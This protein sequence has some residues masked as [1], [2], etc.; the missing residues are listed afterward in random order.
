MQRKRRR[1]RASQSTPLVPQSLSLSLSSVPS[2]RWPGTHSLV[3]KAFRSSETIR[4]IG[5]E[6]DEKSDV[7]GQ[8]GE[9]AVGGR[10][11][12]VSRCESWSEGRC[13][14]DD[15]L[16]D[17]YSQADEPEHEGAK[18]GEREKGIEQGLERVES[19]RAHTAERANQV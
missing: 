13:D 12:S 10:E 7:G 4:C 8:E 18:E 17:S 11:R 2:K 6:H 19:H 14:S 5:L 16:S 9:S 15:S 3:E 1:S